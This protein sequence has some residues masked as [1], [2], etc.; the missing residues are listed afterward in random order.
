[1]RSHPQHKLAKRQMN[2]FSGMINFRIQCSTAKHDQ[3]VKHLKVITPAVSLGHDE[4]LIL[5]HPMVKNVDPWYE[6]LKETTEDFGKG[7]LRFSV[8]LEDP[9]DLIDDLKQALKRVV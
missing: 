3:F 9:A 5:H 6:I 2:G 4:S 1:M 8:G 7:F